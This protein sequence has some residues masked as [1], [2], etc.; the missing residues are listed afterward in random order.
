MALMVVAV[1][2]ALS[3]GVVESHSLIPLV[4]FLL[5]LPTR[6]HYLLGSSLLMRQ[7]SLGLAPHLGQTGAAVPRCWRDWLCPYPFP[8]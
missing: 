8:C 5:L 3:R 6:P 2:W 1:V 7:L 4:I